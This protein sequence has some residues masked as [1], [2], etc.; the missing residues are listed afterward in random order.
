MHAADSWQRLY[1]RFRVITLQL[2]TGKE[3]KLFKKI[4]AA[5]DLVTVCDAPVLTAAQIAEQN[6][7]KLHILHVLESASTENRHL[8]K[9]F[10]TGKDIFTSAEYEETVKEEINKI[11]AEVLTPSLNYEIRVTLGFPWQEILRWAREVSADLIVIG[12]H[13]TRAEEKGV[14]RVAG[15]VG[16]TVEGVITRENC[17]AMIVNPSI[18]KERLKFKKVMV[19]V[20]FSK[21]CECGLRFAVNVAQTFESKLFIFHML[22]IPP[23]PKYTR[24]DYEEDV[25]NSKKRLGE[26]CRGI[27]GGIDYEYSVCGGALPHLEILKYADKKDVDLIVMGSH[28][29]EKAG[30]WYAGSVVERVSF[31]SNCAVIVITDPKILLPWEDSLTTKTQ[32]GKDRDR[33]IH[34]YSK[35]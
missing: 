7:A 17:P 8:I 30:K 12:P 33:L 32:S 24:K 15:K 16:S 35:T 21:F 2:M 29:K 26:F 6:N 3:I 13:S 25:K 9:H 10:I 4:L 34:V 27:P 23:Y 20:D 5:T 14:V 31:R 11:Y 19:S 28:T 18:L 1:S 22:P